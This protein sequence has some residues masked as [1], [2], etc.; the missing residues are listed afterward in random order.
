M[1]TTLRDPDALIST[2]DLATR[3]GQPGLRV[4]D[5]T[6]YLDP[7]DPGSDDP[8]KVVAGRKTFVAGH[9]PGAAFLDLQG[10]LSASARRFNFTMPAAEHLARALG[11]HGRRRRYPRRALRVAP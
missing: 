6:T 10:K 7:P 5:C 3:L 9:I 4:Y 2:D 1:T 11:R 8:Y